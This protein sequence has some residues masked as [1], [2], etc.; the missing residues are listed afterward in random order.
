MLLCVINKLTEKLQICVFI[1]WNFVSGTPVDFRGK[2]V[3]DCRIIVIFSEI[4]FPFL[5]PCKSILID[6][7]Y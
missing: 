5:Q 1:A 3:F 6:I 7:I 2:L 4:T